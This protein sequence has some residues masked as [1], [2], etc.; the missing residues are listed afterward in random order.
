MHPAI[1]RIYK[2]Q[3]ISPASQSRLTFSN[4]VI[5]QRDAGCMSTEHIIATRAH[6]SQRHAHARPYE[7]RL[8]QF[9]PNT[10]VRLQWN[11]SKSMAHNR[12]YPRPAL[13]MHAGHT[14]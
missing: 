11:Y 2:G 10:A 13:Q 14:E 4:E 1:G 9:A 3:F 5:E 8:V 12:L 7:E 6:A